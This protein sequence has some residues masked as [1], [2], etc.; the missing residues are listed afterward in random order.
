LSAEGT[1]VHYLQ[2]IQSGYLDG[3]LAI[4]SFP[5]GSAMDPVLERN[6]LCGGDW[7]YQRQL[8]TRHSD[9]RG[10]QII[11]EHLIELGHRDI[12]VISVPDTMNFGAEY[13]LIG[14]QEACAAAGLDF[15]ALPIAYGDW[16]TPSGTQCAA[17][18]LA[19]HPHLTAL[20]CMND[21]M[22][23][24]AILFATEKGLSVPGDL[25]ITGYDDIPSASF[26]S[27]PLTTVSQRSP[28]QGQA[29]ARMLFDLLE[30]NTPEP[31]ILPPRLIVRQSSGQ[32]AH[33]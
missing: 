28:E 1:D 13:R 27:P 25:T 2:L 23:M 7:V 4:D 19:Q 12:G 11:F 24:G 31:V 10:G 30:G 15:E 32:A 14:L 16:S 3:V 22:A 18:L 20:L 21:R 17:E 9:Q 8:H 6:V 29:A 33:S 26:F 5:L